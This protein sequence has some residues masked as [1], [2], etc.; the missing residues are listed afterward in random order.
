ME[1]AGITMMTNQIANGS[2]CTH[3]ISSFMVASIKTK[4]AFTLYWLCYRHNNGI[5]VVIEAW[6]LAPSTAPFV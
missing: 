6:S 4:G 2:N 3:N 5:S 1:I